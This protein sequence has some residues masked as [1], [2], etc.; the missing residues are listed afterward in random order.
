MPAIHHVTPV[1]PLLIAVFAVLPVGCDEPVPEQ[2]VIAEENL[3]S[4]KSEILNALREIET[5]DAEPS[6]I[7]DVLPEEDELIPEAH[8]ATYDKLR[9]AADELA[10]MES[11]SEVAAK[12]DE[13]TTL[14]ETLPGTADS[15]DGTQE[16][17]VEDDA[18]E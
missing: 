10:E 3:S 6:D 4:I 16:D 5:G 13:M 14:A 12:V 9:A 17:E 11:P 15:G 7:L 2:T 8:R 18:E 1:L